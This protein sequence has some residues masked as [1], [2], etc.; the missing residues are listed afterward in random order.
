MYDDDGG[1]GLEKLAEAVERVARERRPERLALTA[2]DAAMAVT[3][4]R[5]GR[6]VGPVGSGRTGVLALE[7]QPGDDPPASVP[8]T[9]S[10][11][12]EIGRLDVWDAD[13]SPAI[14]AALRVIAAHCGVELELAALRRA[15]EDDV[16]RARRLSA[17][18]GHLRGAEDARTAITLALANTR[19]V[20]GAPAAALVAAGSVRLESAACDGVEGLTE[21]E[22]AVLVPASERPAIAAGDVWHGE[23]DPDGPLGQRGFR[24]VAVAGLGER[25]GLGFLCALG[26]SEDS[27]SDGDVEALGQLATHVTDA[28]T[29]VVLQREV[30]DLGAVD[31]LTRFFNLRYFRTR[32]EQECLRARRTGRALSV[33]VMSLDGLAAVR[34]EGRTG[35]GDAAMQALCRNVTARLRGM[36]VGCRI[37]E[38]E[39][40][41]ILPE[42]EGIDALRI[43]ERIRSSL[44]DDPV[45]A[46]A[47]TLS[48][49]VASFPAQAG[50][51][52]SLH[53]HARSAMAW[54]RG[55]GGDRTFLYDREAASILS[56]EEERRNADEESL[57]ATLLA[58]AESVDDWH[59]TTV[60]H[61]AN[62][63]R[64]AGLIA[65]EMGLPAQRAERVALA[66]RLHD[67]GKSGMR[68]DVVL[69][70][71]LDAGD[72]EELRRHAEIGERMLS[73]C[74]LEDM[75]PW[76]RHHHER[77]DGGG[78]PGGLAGERIPLEARILAVADRFDRLVSGTPA[79]S[80]INADDAAEILRL[81]AGTEFDP[82][83]V[84]ALVAL[85]RRGVT[86][87]SASEDRT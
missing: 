18:A 34:A 71:N 73:G 39:V 77:V 83:V 1:M 22:L 72:A 82:G 33:A 50:D 68:R 42:V 13:P 7:G 79:V 9:G 27:L 55:H 30:R 10:G 59:P 11:G 62:V 75:G 87:R 26:A 78:Y 84:A 3:G 35:A 16:R 74:A 45:L 76:L 51:G 31:P 25:A 20:I 19:A 61:A 69:G 54:A 5:A 40:A 28:L 57:L 4:A 43:G 12:A 17:A 32:L 52:P 58:L 60:G 80:A 56:A 38:D 63:G 21:D 37:G 8:L 64:L 67:L 70:D 86:A 36:D 6:V 66:G 53:E 29:T 44:R 49:G 41:A 65:A 23:L 47:F 2:L 46:G 24:S 81:G 15:R 14:M 48:V 85:L